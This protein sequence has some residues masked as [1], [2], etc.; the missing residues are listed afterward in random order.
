MRN[1]FLLLAV[2]F[3]L[4]SCSNFA[5]V[6]KS[7][8]PE[9]KLKKADEYFSK[10]KYRYAQQLYE[11]L[12]TVYKGNTKF[13]DLYYKYAYSFYHL[14]LYR[15]AE[16][17]FKGY[18]E[19][20]PTSERA[21]EI[22]YMRAY[23]FYKQSPKIDLDQT[24][25]QKAMMMMQTFINTHPGSPRNKEASE[26]IDKSRQKLESK[27]ARGAKLYFDLGHYRAA[28]IAYDNL[29]N[30]FPESMKAEEYKL[31]VIKSYYK[32]AQLSIESRKLERY[33][34][35]IQECDDFADRFPDGQLA[36]EA[37]S[38]KNLSLNQIKELKNEQNPSS[39]KL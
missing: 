15:D 8:D 4:S 34:K 19:V 33:E 5:K 2:S 27:E 21:E 39:A 37:A 28:G 25:T 30:S 24:N 26:I 1:L 23:S 7:K 32:F 16:N 29:M 10:K 6:Q 38:F 12:F 18:L 14:G 22:D 3:L 11:E 13:E 31:Q 17:L 35:V 20:F 36:K 9:Y